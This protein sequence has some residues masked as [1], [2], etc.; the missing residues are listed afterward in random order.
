MRFLANIF[1]GIAFFIG[2]LFGFAHPVPVPVVA[3][4]GTQ[5]TTSRSAVVHWVPATLASL[6]ISGMNAS[7]IQIDEATLEIFATSTNGGYCWARDKSNIYVFDPEVYLATIPNADRDSFVPFG[8][9]GEFCYGKDKRAAYYGHA[10]DSGVVKGADVKSFVL[11]RD[12]L[13]FAKDDSHVFYAAQT[14]T[15]ADPATFSVVASGSQDYAKDSRRVWWFETYPTE[16]LLI[17]G[18]DPGTFV[19]LADGYSKDA[20]HVFSLNPLNYSIPPALIPGADPATF[21]VSTSTD[22]YDAYDKN[23]KYLNGQAVK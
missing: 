5:D 15:G 17:K 3:T 21:V 1:A 2:S 16:V 9:T 22:G 14:I 8:T 12:T 23:H 4:T 20:K 6:G 19:V 10:S 7:H 18:A 11:V 13:L